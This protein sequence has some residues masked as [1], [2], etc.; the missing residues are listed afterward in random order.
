MFLILKF[1]IK[2]INNVNKDKHVEHRMLCIVK[3]N[4]IGEIF[5]KN[6]KNRIKVLNC[7][8]QGDS[9]MAYNVS[10][11]IEEVIEQQVLAMIYFKN[12]LCKL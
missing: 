6:D 8:G 9:T 1:I 3:M 10:R 12:V 11:R 4:V 5:I 2:M 7:K